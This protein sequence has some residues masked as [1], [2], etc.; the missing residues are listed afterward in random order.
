MDIKKIREANLR[1]LLNGKPFGGQIGKFAEAVG[2]D[3]DYISQILSPKSKAAV[4][5]NLARRIEKALN[6]PESWMD[7][8]QNHVVYADFGRQEP[9]QTLLATV[10]EAVDVYFK[11]TKIPITSRQ[12]ATLTKLLVEHFAGRA[13]APTLA[14]CEAKII[15]ISPLFIGQ[16]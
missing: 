2:T 12:K 14:E 9:D 3:A 8:L 4:G 10:L 1:I 7:T 15:D 16:G 5:H 6:K 13:Q 11:G